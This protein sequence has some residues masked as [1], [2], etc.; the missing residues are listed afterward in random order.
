MEKH[1]VLIDSSLCLSQCLES[2]L[3]QKLFI[4][5]PLTCYCGFYSRIHGFGHLCSA[6]LFHMELSE[7]VTWA[8]VFK[9][10][11][12]SSISPCLW[13]SS[14]Y[15]GPSVLLRRRRLRPH[16]EP[17][18]QLRS[19]QRGSRGLQGCRVCVSKSERSHICFQGG[20]TLIVFRPLK[21]LH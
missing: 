16:L 21:A 8:P 2:A 14:A 17:L 6:S 3:A 15:V 18:E 19:V 10:A 13:S 1:F 12:K 20:R 11:T 4:S 7:I 9:R 5:A